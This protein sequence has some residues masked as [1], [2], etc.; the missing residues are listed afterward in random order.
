MT[1]RGPAPKH[2][3]DL[4]RVIEAESWDVIRSTLAYFVRAVGFVAFQLPAKYPGE[5][6]PPFP[7]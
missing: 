4:D 3:A 6:P 5:V 7:Q 2:C 1:E